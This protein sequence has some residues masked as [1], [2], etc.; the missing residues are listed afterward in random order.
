MSYKK[1]L[2]QILYVDD[3]KDNLTVFNSAFRRY[4][5]IHLASSGREGLEIMKKHE[6]QLVITDQRMPGMTGTDFLE[7]IIPDYPDCIRVILTGFSDIDAVIQAINKGQVSRYI[8]KPWDMEE[9]KIMI[10]N[11]LETYNLKMQNRRLF[12]E[13][14]EANINLEQ[15][16]IDRTKKIEDQNREITNS[17]YYAS[18]IQNALLPP[19]HEL[20]KLLPSYFVLNKPRDIIGGDYYW[21]AK[22]DDK[23][24][25][26]VADCTGHGVPGSFMSIL[27]ITLL[28]EIVNKSSTIRANDI[29]NQ[30]RGNI[31]KSLH[32]SRSKDGT[33]DGI[34]I[35]LCIINFSNNKLQFSGAF[36]PLYYISDNEMNEL[37]G[38]NMPIGIYDDEDISFT[39][40][41]IIFKKNDI[42]YLFT[43]GYVDQIGGAFRK[44]FR[45]VNFKKLLLG[46]HEQPM[47]EQKR[48]LEK[49]IDKWRGDIEQV[50]DILVVGIKL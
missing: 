14:K 46:I 30:L 29:L 22:K 25:A 1:P 45:S 18:R 35:A 3:E 12:E 6:I 4:Y 37:S 20:D 8:T 32:Q 34:E 11:G 2:P 7:K 23:V 24:I 16:V 49:T 38:D 19:S 50:D 40:K 13:L 39:S 31:I 44:T 28:N 27:G 48:L 41:E 15:K 33:R 17:I 21:L 10:D 5:E 42:I 26:A 36:R 9:M 43:D 47:E